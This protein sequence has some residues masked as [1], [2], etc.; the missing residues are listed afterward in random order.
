MAPPQA[1]PQSPPQPRAAF[2]S[3][4]PLEPVLVF[5]SSAEARS[6]T[7]FNPLGR[8]YPR[9]TDWVF[10]PLPENLMRVQTTR[11]GDIAFVFKTKQQAESW[12]R[13]IGSVGRHYAE[14]GAAELKLRTVYVGDRL[15]M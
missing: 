15:I 9:H 14:Q 1:P 6:Y 11:K 2:L 12:H 10:L 4:H 8:I 5:S 3:V 13:E 7:G